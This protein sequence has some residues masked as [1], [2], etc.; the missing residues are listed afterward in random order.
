MLTAAAW[1]RISHLRH[2]LCPDL[3]SCCV[4]LVRNFL[5][6]TVRCPR[7]EVIADKTDSRLCL[8]ADRRTRVSA[9]RQRPICLVGDQTRR[10]AGLWSG[11]GAHHRC[12][13]RGG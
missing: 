4:V 8:T 9:P 6:L 11:H 5:V 1:L 7:R 2:P 10:D 12:C 3:L 13:P